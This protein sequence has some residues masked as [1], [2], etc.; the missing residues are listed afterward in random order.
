METD[1][2]LEVTV[3]PRAARDALE[4][5]RE[6]ILRVRVTAAPVNGAANRAV[7][8]LVARALEVAP[9]RVA[10][11]AGERGR[12]KRLRISGMTIE[13]VRARLG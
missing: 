1:A 5:L 10:L 8:Q 2:I 11:M 6:G 12:R 9:S 13:A 7:Q 4:G 3:A